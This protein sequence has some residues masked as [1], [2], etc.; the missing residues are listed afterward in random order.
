MTFFFAEPITQT[1]YQWASVCMKLS[2]PR[3]LLA[4][5]LVC[6]WLTGASACLPAQRK[7]NYWSVAANG[8]RS[9]VYSRINNYVQFGRVA[10]GAQ[11]RVVAAYEAAQHQIAPTREPIVYQSTLPAGVTVR[12]GLVEISKDAPYEA[13]GRFEVGY[14]WESEGLMANIVGLPKE[15]EIAPDLRRLAAVI[16]ADVLIVEIATLT[17]RNGEKRVSHVKGFALKDTSGGLG[18]KTHTAVA[19]PPTQ[20]VRLRYTP[21][22]GCPTT[23]E[24]SD[25]IA[26]QLGYSPW[27]A[28]GDA[29]AIS[30][31]SER[32]AYFVGLVMPG[33]TARTFSAAT[34]AEAIAA[35]RAALLVYLSGAPST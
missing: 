29:V 19:P 9:A 23:D 12:D 28:N 30:V 18:V 21:P 5:I 10:L 1:R 25:D 14:F 34:C 13:V 33:S 26:A 6:A 15:P 11:E 2:N 24:V 22:A 20:R 35:A 27:D 4:G 31:T 8:Q 16:A 3:F 7:S 32:G 17:L